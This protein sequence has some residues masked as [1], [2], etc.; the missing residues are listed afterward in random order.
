MSYCGQ[1]VAWKLYLILGLWLLDCKG[2]YMGQTSGPLSDCDTS[3]NS[4]KSG[5][6]FGLMCIYYIYDISHKGWPVARKLYLIFRLW[7]LGHGGPCMG[8]TSGPLLDCDT[9]W[10]SWNSGSIKGT[11]MCNILEICYCG[12]AVARNLYLI[13]WL[14][15][16]DCKGLYMDQSF[17]PVSD[18][19]TSWDSWKSGSNFGLMC[20]YYISGISHK[21][22]PVVRKLYLI[23]RLW[24]LDHGGP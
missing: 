20:I 8:Q 17:G 12:Q 19:D 9:S 24:M 4:C 21:G 3:W 5:S 6:N 22:W 18:C 1:A 11:P 7:M 10:N 13:L 14:W 16:L 23:F 2:P 15:M